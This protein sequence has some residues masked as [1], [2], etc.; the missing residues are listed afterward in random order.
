MLQPAQS[1]RRCLASHQ[2]MLCR[3][4]TLQESMIRKADA[5]PMTQKGEGSKSRKCGVESLPPSLWP[6]LA[7]HLKFHGLCV[8]KGCSNY[9]PSLPSMPD[10]QD[11]GF[12]QEG[13]FSCLRAADLQSPFARPES[14]DKSQHVS[15]FVQQQTLT[16]K[17]ICLRWQLLY[18]KAW[19]TME[20]MTLLLSVYRSNFRRRQLPN[21]RSG[22]CSS[23]SD[24]QTVE[25]PRIDS[26]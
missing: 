26:I 19:G 14:K 22:R 1:S 10:G 11:D 15:N 12:F 2:R 5:R 25:C 21:K 9:P 8:V 13:D 17:I 18:M 6:K 24:R 16:R 7:P 3:R 23:K 4:K 20:E